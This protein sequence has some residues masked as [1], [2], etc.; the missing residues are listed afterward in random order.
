MSDNARNNPHVHTHGHGLTFDTQRLGNSLGTIADWRDTVV[1]PEDVGIEMVKVP[2]GREVELDLT[3]S[4]VEDG[5]Y[6]AGTVSAD[7]VAECVRCLTELTRHADVTIGDL[8]AEPGS[9]SAEAAEEEEVRLLE[10][11][12][13]DLT[14]ALID[15]FGLSFEL[16]PTCESVTGKPC[17]E[18]DVPAPDGTAEDWDNAID[19]RWAGLAQKFGRDPETGEQT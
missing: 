13:V 19:P 4:R 16:A 1:L 6:V 14:Q 9:P 7:A 8:Y 2:A 10:D 15:G 5:V 3:V 17:P 18:G 11:S 12:R